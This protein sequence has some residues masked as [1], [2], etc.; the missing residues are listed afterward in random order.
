[1]V[2]FITL[3][4]EQNVDINQ[5]LLNADNQG[6]GEPV[7]NGAWRLNRLTPVVSSPIRAPTNKS[8]SR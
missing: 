5:E 1:M 7:G 8:G 6:R 2:V 4:T 3:F